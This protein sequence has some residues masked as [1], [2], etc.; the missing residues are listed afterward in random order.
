M[1]YSIGILSTGGVLLG[2]FIHG[3][4][5]LLFAAG[6]VPVLQPPAY[7]AQVQ[8]LPALGSQ[9]VFLCL[10]GTGFCV[11]LDAFGLRGLARGEALA[12]EAAQGLA[13]LGRCI[14]CRTAVCLQVPD[15]PVGRVGAF[16]WAFAGL[17]TD[18]AHWY[19]FLHFPASVL[20]L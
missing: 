13:G 11:P 12:G 17:R 16:A 15:F 1:W 9:L 14:S 3:I 20:S 18:F 2:F 6:A 10:G 5:V 4:L 19:F 7:G 8:E